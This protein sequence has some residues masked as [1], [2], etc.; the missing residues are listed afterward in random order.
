MPLMTN[1]G[2]LVVITNNETQK[3]VF[4]GNL[5]GLNNKIIIGIEQPYLAKPESHIE[6]NIEQIKHHSK[7]TI[8]DNLYC[9]LDAEHNYP[10][11]DAKTHTV[12]VI[13]AN[14]SEFKA[15]VCNN[16]YDFKSNKWGEKRH[17][18]FGRPSC[19]TDDP[20]KATQAVIIEDMGS[21]NLYMIINGIQCAVK[22]PNI[23]QFH[24]RD[25][26]LCIG[27]FD[28]VEDP[29]NPDMLN[30]VLIKS[31]DAEYKANILN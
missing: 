2:D 24:N 27:M 22:A 10:S 17:G 31:Y 26:D 20:I 1:S 6:S 29:N 5:L 28:L 23:N 21:E 15:D 9:W 11:F 4:S 8:E 14:E 3:Q 12:T 16:V 25:T 30:A 13:K 7:N 19:V 18:R